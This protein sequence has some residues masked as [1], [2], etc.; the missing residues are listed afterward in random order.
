MRDWVGQ[1]AVLD[2]M[3]LYNPGRPAELTRLLLRYIVCFWSHVFAPLS[4]AVS[5]LCIAHVSAFNGIA[6]FPLYVFILWHVGLLLGNDR[7]ISNYT[8]AVAK[9]GLCR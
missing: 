2:T 9:K 4:I 3:K 1:N 5:S 8:T 6:L 7:E